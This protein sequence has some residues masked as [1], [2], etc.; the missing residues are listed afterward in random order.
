M[1]AMFSFNLNKQDIAGMARSHSMTRICPR[2][3]LRKLTPHHDGAFPALRGS[4]IVRP[5]SNDNETVALVQLN[6][7][8][9][10]GAN[11]EENALTVLHAGQANG[12]FKQQASKTLFLPLGGNA[13]VQQVIL[14]GRMG[15]DT[16]SDQLITCL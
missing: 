10:A 8:R 11:L 5:L 13:Q 3:L 1:P 14:P 4:V 2:V 6:S 12:M 15:L 7:S 16:I 9:V